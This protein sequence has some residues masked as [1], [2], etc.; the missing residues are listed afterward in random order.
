MF[1][2]T[3]CVSTRS[4]PCGTL[5][6]LGFSWLFISAP[7]RLELEK[8]SSVTKMGKS[9][10]IQHKCEILEMGSLPQSWLMTVDDF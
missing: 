2:P 3:P 8:T 5:R 4:A 1:V 10:G 7:A 9:C 6:S